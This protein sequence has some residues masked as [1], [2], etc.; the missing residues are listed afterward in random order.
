MVLHV[1]LF[2][3]LYSIL[4]ALSVLTGDERMCDVSSNTSTEVEEEMQYNTMTTTGQREW[5]WHAEANWLTCHVSSLSC[6]MSLLT[7]QENNTNLRDPQS[8]MIMQLLLLS[9][10]CKKCQRGGETLNH[11]KQISQANRIID[12]WLCSFSCSQ[13]NFACLQRWRACNDSLRLVFSRH[14]IWSFISNV[15]F[16][17][18]SFLLSFLSLLVLVLC[19]FLASCHGLS[20][21]FSYSLPS[22][23]NK[24]LSKRGR[25]SRETV[26]DY[27]SQLSICS[28]IL[29]TVLLECVQDT[30]TVPVYMRYTHKQ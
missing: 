24:Q 7:S 12:S 3:A 8:K 21:L 20:F 23:T 4:F 19:C 1:L 27:C 13:R 5:G 28:N 9:F 25:Q 15:V 16:P 11:D 2:L 17:S 6:I 22:T 18:I 30:T 29:W 10:I 26:N 14:L